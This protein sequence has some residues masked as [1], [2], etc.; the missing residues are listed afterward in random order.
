[1]KQGSAKRYPYWKNG[2]SV[3]LLV[4]ALAIV[5]LPGA[6]NAG[7]GVGDG[8]PEK[9]LTWQGQPLSTMLPA[10]GPAT[11]NGLVQSAQPF[12]SDTIDPRLAA[13]ATGG[14][15]GWQGMSRKRKIWIAGAIGA[16]AGA[17]FGWL[18]AVQSC[19]RDRGFA[20]DGSIQA[21]TAGG[22]A[23][24]GFGV[25]LVIALSD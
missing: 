3:H 17:A 15:Q 6:A 16:G 1:M 18:L 5:G 12:A 20:C 22:F 21:A 10:S 24:L 8:V 11:A 9:V 2:L 4:M 23:L 13:A 7:P 14:W 19:Q 25:G